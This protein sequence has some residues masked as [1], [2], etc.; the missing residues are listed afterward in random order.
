MKVWNWLNGRKTYIGGV[1]LTLGVILTEVVK[2][3]WG[4]DPTWMEPT[5]KTFNWTGMFITGGGWL[6]KG[7]KAVNSK[8]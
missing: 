4:Y 2:G 6:H 7:T 8:Q 1:C 3:F 5:I